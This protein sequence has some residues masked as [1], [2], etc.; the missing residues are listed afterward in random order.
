MA[1]VFHFLKY[2]LTLYNVSLYLLSSAIL[3]IAWGFGSIR[4]DNA[5]DLLVVVG[6]GILLTTFVT[7]VLNYFF[8]DQIA[9]SLVRLRD[10]LA[11]NFSIVSE[12]QRSGIVGMYADRGQAMKEINAAFHQ[13]VESIDIIAVSGT[14]FFHPMC[15]LINILDQRRAANV[16]MNIRVL[17]LH[18]LSIHAIERAYIEDNVAEE[19]ATLLEALSKKIY[20]DTSLAKNSMMSIGQLSSLMTANSPGDKK[21]DF[22]LRVRLFETAP[23]LLYCRIGS[24]HFVEQYHYGVHPNERNKAAARCLGQKVPVVEY[25]TESSAGVVYRE[26]FR[27]MWSTSKNREIKP[28][29]EGELRQ[30]IFDAAKISDLYQG[31]RS[32]ADKYDPTLHLHMGDDA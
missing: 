26:H 10:E 9:K 25:A 19:Y 8:Q 29:T 2:Q 7:N 13:Q 24:R 5:F 32:T 31:I 30:I 16:K 6:S 11:R 18:P 15:D 21:N 3:L 17:L 12:A 14:T 20:G 22:R 4:M 1:S 28:S 27:Y 23:Q